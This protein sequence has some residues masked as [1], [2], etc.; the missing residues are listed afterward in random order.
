MIQYYFSFKDIF[1]RIQSF[2]F[3]FFLLALLNAALSKTELIAQ[4]QINKNIIKIYVVSSN[5]NYYDPW[6]MRSQS[7]STGS[8]CIIAGKRILTSAHVIS[9]HTFIQVKRAGMAQ[10]YIAEVQF[11]AHDL[12]LAILTVHDD[13]FFENIIPVPI[14]NLAHVRDRV[15]VYGFPKGGTEL[16]ITEGV[17]SRIEH[18]YYTHSNSFLLTAQIDAAIN[19]GNSGG[20][21][22]K[23]GKI[24]GVAF[25]G[26]SN[27]DNIGYMVPGPIIKQFLTDVDDGK[28]HGL[29]SLG[30]GLQKMEN[31]TLRQRFQ[32]KKNQ[33]GVLIRNV[34]YGSAAYGILFADDILINIDGYNVANDGTI[35][36]RPEERTYFSFALQQKQINDFCTFDIWRKGK[37]LRKKIQLTRRINTL[38]LVPYDQYEKEPTY[39]IIGGL[40][41][42]PLS[43]NLLKEWGAQWYNKAPKRLL[44][45]YYY[46]ERTKI[47]NQEVILVKVLA[48]ELN[49]GYHNLANLVIVRVNGLHIGSMKDL[50]FAFKNNKGQYHEIIDNQNNIIVLDRNKVNH[51]HQKILKKYKIPNDRSIDLR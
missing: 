29:P 25:Q 37:L 50:I 51:Y 18:R 40:L 5:F 27:A 12:D 17:V 14:G 41:F 26:H 16:S 48:D 24:V 15:S 11:V 33:T 21:V 30:I 22:I 47:K 32:M 35:E 23:N 31:D 44:Y 34:A 38:E 13:K 10:K 4:E 6:Q 43:K 36:F 45:P 42:M 20:P 1:M 39:F 46:G 7:T 3:I 28:L 49:V 19:S 2:F 9:N 8:G